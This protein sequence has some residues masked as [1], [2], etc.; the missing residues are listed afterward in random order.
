LKLRALFV[1]FDEK[2][3]KG[4]K[5]NEVRLRRYRH[6][7]AAYWLDRRL[8]LRMVP[9]T[10]IRNVNGKTGALQI[11]IESAVDRV[12]VEEQNLLEKG[13]EELREQIDKAWVLEAVLDVEK[14]VKEGQLVLP[15]ERR[16]MLS[17]STLAFSHFPEIQKDIC[18]HLSCPINPSLENELRTLT[19]EELKESLAEYLS[20]GQIDALLKRRDKVLEL[21]ANNNQ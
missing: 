6:E 7:V 17:G 18:P 3:P 19:R 4:K 16:I 2:P 12:W 13:R 11:L 5:E 9:V 14:R 20:D 21:C 8:K 1:S 15:E 10:V